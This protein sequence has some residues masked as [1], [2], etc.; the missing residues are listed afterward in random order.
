MKSIK[1]LLRS[2][3][4]KGL[5]DRYKYLHYLGGVR[6][7]L[8]HKNR[9]RAI[10][11]KG[12][13]NVLFISS[14]LPMWRYQ[15]IYDLLEAD[16]RFKVAIM[17][18]PFPTFSERE[19]AYSVEQLQQYFA[20]KGIMAITAP[21]NSGDLKRWLDDFNP[22]IMFYP[23]NY[24]HLYGSPLDSDYFFDRLLCYY[25]YAL[26]T[27]GASWN[28]NTVFNNLAWRH[29]IPTQFHKATLR[30]L[31]YNCDRNSRIV[32][33]PHAD[34]FFRSDTKNPW[35]P[36]SDGVRRKRVIFA[37]HFRIQNKGV[38][39]RGAFQWMADEM[40]ELAERYKDRIQFAF[41]PHPRLFSELE[42]L[43]SWGYE[44][45]I[46][47]YEKWA[48]MPNTQLEIGDFIE[49][50]N[51]SDAIIHNCGSFTGEYLFT[52][53]PALFVT[54]DLDIVKKDADEFGRVCL[55]LHYKAHSMED[56]EEFISSVVLSGNDPM[57]SEREI[58]RENNL[59]PPGTGN[60]AMNTY[61]DIL[62]G[63]KF[64]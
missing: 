60:V 47:Y 16:S 28:Y 22:D 6:Y 36:V 50:F 7:E 46:S 25:D 3:L 19:Q 30:R 62:K 43:D 35:K 63:L 53:K 10:R 24:E 57:K 40:I 9:I 17:I 38:F 8:L 59:V 12:N 29:Y 15:G 33:E 21:E 26:P 5:I 52:A 18:A 48:T 34:L 51:T 14:S 4:P 13:A 61:L 32:G 45:S 31:A 55:D 11:R 54:K 20:S 49:L 41:K 44:K 37:P 39:R 64:I 56:V 58:F 27:V 42:R 1:S 2:Y 23:Q